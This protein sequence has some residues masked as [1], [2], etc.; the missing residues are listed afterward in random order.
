MAENNKKNNRKVT[1]NWS[2]DEERTLIQE[3]E[4]RPDL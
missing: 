1:K 4:L 2:K 3:L